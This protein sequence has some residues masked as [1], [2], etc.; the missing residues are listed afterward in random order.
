MD[1]ER[2]DQ[3]LEDG[4]APRLRMFAQPRVSTSGRYVDST[5]QAQRAIVRIINASPYLD[6]SLGVLGCLTRCIAV[7]GI[8]SPAYS[9]SL[10][11]Y[12]KPESRFYVIRNCGHVAIEFQ[13]S[14]K[15]LFLWLRASDMQ[16][17][18]NA[19]IAPFAVLFCVVGGERFRAIGLAKMMLDFVALYKDVGGCQG[20]DVVSVGYKFTASAVLGVMFCDGGLARPFRRAKARALER[21][22]GTD[23]V[24][25]D[26]FHANS[27]GQ[28]MGMRVRRRAVTFWPPGKRVGCSRQSYALLFD[29]TR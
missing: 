21:E 20:F 17:G 19:P 23:L 11:G 26:Q 22:E 2:P 10:R 9:Y 4:P 13:E 15:G 3:V 12:F 16:W 29:R 5:V 7:S 28:A 8:L 14:M 18:I 6:T 27:L 25:V 24:R 1:D